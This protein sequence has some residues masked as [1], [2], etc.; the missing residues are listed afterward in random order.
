MGG[1]C[2]KKLSLAMWGGFLT[3]L[4]AAG[5]VSTTHAAADADLVAGF[6]STTAIFTENKS[7]IISYVVG[8]MLVIIVIGLIIRGLFFGKRQLMGVF[9]GGRRKK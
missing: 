3:L 6:A 8:I 5:L 2:M 9:G 7:A 1:E 4:G